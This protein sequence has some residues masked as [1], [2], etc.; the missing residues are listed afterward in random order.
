MRPGFWFFLIISILAG[1]YAFWKVDN[2][3]WDRSVFIFYALVDLFLICIVTA[4]GEFD[5][6]ETWMLA[7]LMGAN[8][9][10]WSGLGL[11]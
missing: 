4:S 5:S 11:R 1:A 7:G 8:M 9:G 6:M 3:K 2:W 10:C